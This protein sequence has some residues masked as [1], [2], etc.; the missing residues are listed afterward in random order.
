MNLDA[1]KQSS[2][3]FADSSAVGFYAGLNF[4]AWI[5]IFCF[6]RETKRL[7]LE[8]LDRKYI[9]LLPRGLRLT[10][11]QRC[12]R[13]RQRSSS[14]MNSRSGCPGSSIGTSSDEMSLAH[15]RSLL[16]LRRRSETRLLEHSQ[17]WCGQDD[18]ERWR[19]SPCTGTLLWHWDAWLET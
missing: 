4:I 16:L 19:V 12:S 1:G 5:M 9:C 2:R 14:I 18:S 6:V 3:W 13:C 15:L 17:K 8:E 10:F 7:T 11:S